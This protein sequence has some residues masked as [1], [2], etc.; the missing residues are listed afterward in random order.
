MKAAG[1]VLLLGYLS[2]GKQDEVPPFSVKK[3]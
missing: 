1:F 3:K 2:F